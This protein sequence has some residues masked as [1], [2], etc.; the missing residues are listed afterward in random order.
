M[1][2]RRGEARAGAPRRGPGAGRGRRS[3]AVFLLVGLGF[4]TAAFG[5][6]A[7]IRWGTVPARYGRVAVAVEGEALVVRDERVIFAEVAGKIIPVAQEGERVARGALIARIVTGHSV[8][9]ESQR[10]EEALREAERRAILDEQSPLAATAAAGEATGTS[11]TSL[12]AVRR[13]LE[14]EREALTRQ[15]AG[16]DQL[17]RA[18]IAGTVSYTID[19]LEG[20]LGPQ[21]LA[22]LLQEAVPMAEV[23]RAAEPRVVK[24]Q[25]TVVPGRPAAKVVNNFRVWFV[26]DLPP[27]TPAL[28]R[29]G[30]PVRLRLK[31]AGTP[32][33]AACRAV[34]TDR[35]EWRGGTRLLLSSVEY[36]PEFGR[37]RRTGL[38]ILLEEYEGVWVPRSALV[39]RE[40][41]FGV[42]SESWLGRQF[43]PVT[44]RGGDGERVVVDG[45]APGTRVW[46]RP[47]GDG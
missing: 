9:R 3:R 20:I 6:Q 5:R 32:P 35:R 42:M 1:P 30:G 21:S 29:V 24:P 25:E 31:G 37:V 43:Q 8:E 19:G 44:V 2:P 22:G 16:F 10:I 41:I 23:A 46:K 28:P 13:E 38:E 47:R 40:G 33:G 4:L 14:K 39:Q 27:G 17:T 18:P 15:A 45:L 12:A 34:V 26:V 7:V 36:W 11:G